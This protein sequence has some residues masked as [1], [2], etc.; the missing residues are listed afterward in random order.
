MASYP[1]IHAKWFGRKQ[2]RVLRVVIHGTVSPTREGQ[3][4]ATAQ[5]FAR[6]VRPSSAH[7]TVDPGAIWQSLPEDVIAYHDG[8]N[9]ESIGV[10]LC[11]MVDG[12]ADRWIRPVHQHMLR[13]AARLVNE[14][15]ERY[16]IP[17]RRL[18]PAQIR[19]GEKGICGHVDMRD[20]FPG[21]TTHYDPGASFPWA[22]FLVM[23]RSLP[24]VTPVVP[25]VPAPLIPEDAMYI[26]CEQEDKSITLGIWS[27]GAYVPL[28]TQGEKDSALA[29]IRK[30]ATEQWVEKS[31]Y[32]LMVQKGLT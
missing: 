30:G 26:W 16:D 4:L 28:L 14:L 6:V 29:A 7:Y 31:T 20:A 8:T 18:T 3:A 27:G 21:S 1:F 17:I 22:A 9:K 23:V 10:E 12:S 19:N 15:C 32:K 25:P 24:P 13:R 5:Y 2:E 11:D